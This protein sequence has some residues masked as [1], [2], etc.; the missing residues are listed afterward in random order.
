[1]V[2]KQDSIHLKVLSQFSQKRKFCNFITDRD[3]DKTIIYTFSTKIPLK[4]SLVVFID[5]M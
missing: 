3:I 4:Q 1:M 2:E 5:Y